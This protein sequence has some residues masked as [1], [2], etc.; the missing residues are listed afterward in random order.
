MLG[1]QSG[2]EHHKMAIILVHEN[3][4]GK[5]DLS[6]FIQP[7]DFVVVYMRKRNDRIITKL[8]KWYTIS[9]NDPDVEAEVHVIYTP[10]LD[11]MSLS[12][13]IEL[14]PSKLKQVKIFIDILDKNVDIRLPED[15]FDEKESEVLYID[16]VGCRH[17]ESQVPTFSMETDDGI[18]WTLPE[19]EWFHQ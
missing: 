15:L 7:E 17:K 3:L 10:E 19:G 5:M 11:V 16:T 13:I 6:E 8:K 4:L 14:V 9:V 12:S 18:K 2:K 1:C